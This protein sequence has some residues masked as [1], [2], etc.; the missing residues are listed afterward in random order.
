[1]KKL[2]F[3]SNL[4]FKAQQEQKR[5]FAITCIY[6]CRWVRCRRYDFNRDEQGQIHFRHCPARGTGQNKMIARNYFKLQAAHA[7]SHGRALRCMAFYIP[8]QKH[9]TAGS[10]RMCFL[11][12]CG[13]VFQMKNKDASPWLCNLS[14]P[15]RKSHY[16]L[17]TWWRFYGMGGPEY[18]DTGDGFLKGTL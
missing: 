3:Y 13:K 16:S 14:I 7:I 6:P 12:V 18:L 15:F 11:V 4:S 1:M 10:C 2:N 5:I 8:H 9:V 17:I